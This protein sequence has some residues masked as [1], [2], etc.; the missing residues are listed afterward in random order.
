V[1]VG[2]D[3]MTEAQIADARAA[4]SDLTKLPTRSL[5]FQR[6]S[7]SMVRL[8]QMQRVAFGLDEPE[9]PPLVDE[10]ADLS[11]EELEVRIHER[12]ARL[13]ARREG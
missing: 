3:D 11:D 12:L 8:Q 10:A 6:L 2:V 1:L 7:Q 4:L 5:A 13:H 9:Q